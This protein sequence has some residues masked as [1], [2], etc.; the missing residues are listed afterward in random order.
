MYLAIKCRLGDV[1]HHESSMLML[2]CL[3]ARGIGT[4]GFQ[5]GSIITRAGLVMM[6][7][8]VSMLSF[9][10]SV[11]VVHV[12]GVAFHG[13]AREQGVGWRCEVKVYVGRVGDLDSNCH[14]VPK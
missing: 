13:Q 3:D 10:M 4:N 8:W 2:L 11:S 1:R 12:E 9:D 7:G 14:E 5:G 6:E